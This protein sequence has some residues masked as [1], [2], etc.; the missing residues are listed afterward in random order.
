M[1]LAWYAL[2][3]SS[4]TYPTCLKSLLVSWS[5]LVWLQDG[6][7]LAAHAALVAKML[8]PLWKQ[9]GAGAE[10]GVGAGAA[11]TRTTQ[12]AGALVTGLPAVVQVNPLLFCSRCCRLSTGTCPYLNGVAVSAIAVSGPLH[13]KRRDLSPPS[14]DHLH[15]HCLAGQHHNNNATRSHVRLHTQCIVFYHGEE[16]FDT[17]DMGQALNAGRGRGGRYEGSSRGGGRSQGRGNQ[18]QGQDRNSQA[19]VAPPPGL[20]QGTL[21]H[22]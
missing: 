13:S 16:T 10:A 6:W 14:N 11:M 8:V 22:C 21:L 9:A 7:R 15:E 3:S 1:S 20:H 18:Y 19:P 5:V 4:S 2:S 17:V 12:E